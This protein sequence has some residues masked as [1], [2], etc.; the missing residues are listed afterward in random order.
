MPALELPT[1]TLAFLS[2]V[3]KCSNRTERTILNFAFSSYF[4]IT[5]RISSYPLS[6]F[7]YT[8]SQNR[9]DLSRACINTSAWRCIELNSV[10]TGW[11]IAIPYVLSLIPYLLM[12]SCSVGKLLDD[13]M[14]R[15]GEP[16]T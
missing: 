10:V 5:S 8:T 16:M 6:L 12:L 2:S 4:F 1:I 7:G 11:N 9:P 15:S 3:R 14:S 13:M